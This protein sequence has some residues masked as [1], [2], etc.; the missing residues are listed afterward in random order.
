MMIVLLA[1]EGVPCNQVIP[2]CFLVPPDRHRVPF[3]LLIASPPFVPN[4]RH[5]LAANRL[6]PNNQSQ[7]DSPWGIESGVALMKI[8]FAS[9]Y[10]LCVQIDS[11]L[12]TGLPLGILEI[13][14]GVLGC[15]LLLETMKIENLLAGNY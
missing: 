7:K 12:F 4:P 15:T 14:P 9:L 11:L 6:R 8:P 13:R 2:T 1:G 5:H 3:R 10:E